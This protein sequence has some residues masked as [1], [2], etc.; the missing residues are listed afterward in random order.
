MRQKRLIYYNQ[1]SLQHILWNKL[2]T[3]NFIC[4]K[5]EMYFDI[6][7]NDSAYTNKSGNGPVI[8]V[9]TFKHKRRRTKQISSQVEDIIRPWEFND[10][11]Y[12]N[13]GRRTW[14]CRSP[15]ADNG[16]HNYH[17]TRHARKHGKSNNRR[18]LND[19]QYWHIATSQ[20]QIQ[21]ARQNVCQQ[22]T[23]NSSWINR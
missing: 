23:A 1:T 14:L 3:E 4:N 8:L 17:Q 7:I 2:K 10:A 12:K 15:T 11:G 13:I 18:V 20:F 21:H 16:H 6:Y 5:L 22:R 9:C 19:Q